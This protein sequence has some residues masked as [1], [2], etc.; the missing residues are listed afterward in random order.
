MDQLSDYLSPRFCN[1]C[2]CAVAAA[3]RHGETAWEC[4]CGHAQFRRPTVGVAVVLVDDGNVLLVR[5]AYGERAGQWCFPCGHVGWD[6]DIRA[7]AARELLE[8]TGIVAKVGHVINAHSNTW[9]PDR[10]T[11]GIWFAGTPTGGQLRAGDDADEA[12]YLPLDAIDVPLAFATDAMI[13][14][15]LR[16]DL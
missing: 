16:D 14:D 7:A 12:R 6:E 15:Q 10:Q 3:D 1:Q 5:R 8:E 2:G 4:G 11:I 9:R 13:L